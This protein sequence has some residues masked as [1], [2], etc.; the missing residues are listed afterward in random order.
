MAK[1]ELP[2][3]HPESTDT[4]MVMS[5]S[6]FEA[7]FPTESDLVE[8]K[9][10]TSYRELQRAIV[11]FS[12]T[13]GGVILV[14][15]DDAGRVV[16]KPLTPGVIDA[17][18]QAASS[19]HDPG[20][21]WIHELLVGATR[22]SVVAV[23][24]RTQG[25]AQTSNGE[26]LV[27]RGAHSVPLIGGELKRFM[28]SRALERFDVTD[29][30][31]SISNADESALREV[32]SAFKWPDEAESSALLAD[33]QLAIVEGRAINLT[34]A[35]ALTLL[36]DPAPTLGKAYVEVLRYP[37]EAAEYDRR[38]EIR[39]SV[40]HQVVRATEL[41]MAELGT[42]LVVSG[43]RRYELPRIPEVVLREAVANAVA[44]RSYEDIGQ[45]IEI[46]IFPD[47]VFVV[48]PGGLLEPV[49]EQNIRDTHSARNAV[50]LSTL[51]RFRLAE[52]IGRGIDV[53]QDEMAGALLDPPVFR[54]LGHAFE[55]TLPMRGAISPQ[56]RAWILEVERRGDIRPA[57]RILLVQ[58][59]RGEILTN[60][61]V[62]EL[63]GVDSRDA[64]ASLKRLRDTGF[65]EQ[66]GTRGGTSYVLAQ[67]IAAPPS[68]RLTPR[69]L[70][71][72]VI[73]LASHGEISNADVRRST[74]LDRAEALRLLTA[75]VSGGELVK[76]GQRRGTRYR[77]PSSEQE[78]I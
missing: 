55:V 26:T 67:G 70:S 27:R 2:P 50:V 51:R 52:D 9:S 28:D 54:D 72:L 42:D 11:A 37:S 43:L 41:L 4:P 25:F 48:S 53:M 56:E 47:R 65:L 15:V 46:K 10:G 19:A 76:S 34:V 22:I 38:E 33:A 66:A 62:R 69:D 75:L 30:H 14:G 61:R 5:P 3:F 23:A 71:R 36:P 59:A 6:E 63:L 31:V 39:G 32:R 20:R 24:R 68:F 16:G 78:L 74:G 7:A 17:I 44:H 58:A 40:Q 1:A 45:A 18:H 64:R 49:T 77:L 35:G 60:G 8:R 13:E 12:N 21:Y 57:D 73:E 29:S